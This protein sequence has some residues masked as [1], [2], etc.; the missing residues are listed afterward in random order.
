MTKIIVTRDKSNTIFNEQMKEH[1]HSL[2][3][4]LTE[5]LHVFIKTGLH[6]FGK[7]KINLLE[8]GLG[9]GLNALLTLQDSIEKNTEINYVAI[10]P[11]PLSYDV[12][13]K[14]N[15]SSLIKINEKKIKKIHLCD[16]EKSSMITSNFKFIKYKKTLKDLQIKQKFNLIYF[17]AFS[18]TVQP[19]IWHKSNFKKLHNMMEKKSILVT[20]CS[21]GKVRRDLELSGFFVEKLK[22]PPGKREII[23]AKK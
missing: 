14:L 5:S 18:P 16:F 7:E 21:K 23:R 15:Y 11:Y 20:Y 2:H 3:G 19:N 13:K 22:G 10:E 1:Y 12:I 6:F 8:I 9:T 17:D 4:A